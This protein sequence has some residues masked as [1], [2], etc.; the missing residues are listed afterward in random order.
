MACALWTADAAL[1]W[2][3][4]A[5]AQ[6]VS[7]PEWHVLCGR[8]ML[9]WCGWEQDICH[10]RWKRPAFEAVT[11]LLIFTSCHNQRSPLRMCMQG[12]NDCWHAHL[13]PLIADMPDCLLPDCWH[14]HLRP[15]IADMPD[16]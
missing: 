12:T 7:Q 3:G 10:S 16:C 11:A 14:A 8:L 9:P 4:G 2:L 15:L 5:E 1:E 6:R 13:R